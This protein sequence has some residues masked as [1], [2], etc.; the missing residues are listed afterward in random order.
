MT[1][2]AAC[3][4]A[5]MTT[6][7]QRPDGGLGG[8]G[9][10][11]DARADI[12]GRWV[13]CGTPGFSRTPHV[14]VEFGANGRWRLLSRDASG[15]LVPLATSTGFYYALGSG[16]LNVRGETSGGTFFI[17]FAAGVDALHFR[18]ETAN[19]FNY[20]RTDP[21]PLNGRDNLPSLSDGKCSMLGSWD[22]PANPVTPVVPAATFA[23]DE[24]GNFVGGPLGSDL[25]ASHTMYGTY[26]LSPGFFSLTTNIGLGQCAWWFDA[27][28]PATFDATCSKLTLVQL[29]D[30]CTG[31]RGYFNGTTTLTRRQ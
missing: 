11:G 18:G 24:V 13:A 6:V 29:Y 4:T 1:V 14:A 12:V 31:G 5:S 19:S 25:C 9:Y 21:S 2:E 15:A 28:Y 7:W 23:F 3:A 16:Q 10:D 26:A 17:S 22:V 30:N 8:V 20:A 27:R